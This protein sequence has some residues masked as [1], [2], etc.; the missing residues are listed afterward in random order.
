MMSA[1]DKPVLIIAEDAPLKLA[2]YGH[3]LRSWF[4][5]RLLI[6]ERDGIT[7]DFAKPNVRINC[8]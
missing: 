3:T 5:D 8:A 4:P 2:G 6:W 1:Q 7:T